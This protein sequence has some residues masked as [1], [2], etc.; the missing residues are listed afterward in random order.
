MVFAI[1]NQDKPKSGVS[2]EFIFRFSLVKS[3]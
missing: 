1:F 2:W 3:I